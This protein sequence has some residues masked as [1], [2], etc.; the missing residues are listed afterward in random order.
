MSRKTTQHGRRLKRQAAAHCADPSSIYRVMNRIQ[1]FT[2]AELLSLSAPPRV[3][4][5]SM[6]RGSG[7][8][9]DFHTLAAVANCVLVC[10]EKIGAE[11]VELA[12]LAQESL[13]LI[14]DRHVRLGKWGLDAAALQNIPPVLDLHEQLLA[15]YTPLQ[16]QQ[17]MQTV[18]ERMR[19]GQTL[20]PEDFAH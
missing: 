6:R 17:A 2:Q 12:K 8:E 10:G 20:A 15:L 7:T 9:L 16:M 18:L 14:L 5:E 4:L 3:A 19:V 11:C 1:P 13:M